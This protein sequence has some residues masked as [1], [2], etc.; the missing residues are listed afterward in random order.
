MMVKKRFFL[1]ILI[2]QFIG[3]IPGFTASIWSADTP[4]PGSF[5]P[6]SIFPLLSECILDFSP[7]LHSG[8]KILSI[9]NLE[10][11]LIINPFLDILFM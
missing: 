8:N 7:N 5:P 4:E 1:F 11:R 6:L 3:V 10:S 9:F 2:P